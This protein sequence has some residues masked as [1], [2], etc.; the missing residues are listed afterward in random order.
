MVLTGNGTNCQGTW[1]CILLALNRAAVSYSSHYSAE[2]MRFQE[3]LM[4]H[5][6]SYTAHDA[7]L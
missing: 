4:M 2:L 7:F 3:Y 6:S 5:V 1:Q